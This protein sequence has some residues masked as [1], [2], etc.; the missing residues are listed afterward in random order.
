MLA[1]DE[2]RARPA[3]ALRPTTRSNTAMTDLPAASVA[4]W[5]CT[6]ERQVVRSDGVKDLDA[7]H[8]MQCD[9]GTLQP[10]R[11]GVFVLN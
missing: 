9:D 6:A 1:M 5:I 2:N 7:L 3:C 10:L 4:E 11:I 8:E